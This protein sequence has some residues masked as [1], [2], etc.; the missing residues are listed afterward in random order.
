MCEEYNKLQQMGVDSM[1]AEKG[2]LGDYDCPICKN[3]GV[4]YF[5]NEN[6]DVDTKECECMKKRRTIQRTKNSG[7]ANMLNVYTFKNFTHS[8]D[9]QYYIYDKATDFLIDKTA[10]TFFIGGA[11]GCGKSHI[12]TAIAGK[13]LAQGKYV[14]F[15]VWSNI[16]TQLKQS[17]Y[18]DKDGYNSQLEFLKNIEVLYIDDFF[19]TTPTEA[20]IDKAFKIID[21]RKNMQIGDNGR[22]KKLITIIS[23]EKKISD[24]R[25]ID[26]AIASR[27]YEMAS[28]GEYAVEISNGRDRNQRMKSYRRI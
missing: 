7:L 28:R 10:N 9:W 13:L 19:K 3:K 23:S 1:N 25:A 20:D 21:Y 8:T 16:V 6:G 2:D 5:L 17:V 24:L 14:F 15:D 11:V 12:C 18:E 26:E 27:I 22:E 4:I